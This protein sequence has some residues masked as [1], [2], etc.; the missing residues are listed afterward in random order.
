[1]GRSSHHRIL[2]FGTLALATA[3]AGYVLPGGA[4]LRHLVTNRAALH[5]TT[6][7]AEGTVSFFGGAIS[8]AGAALQ[9]PTDKPETQADATI[10]LRLPGRCR[11]DVTSPEGTRLSVVD[12]QGRLRN[13]GGVVQA[14]NVALGQVCHL[15]ALRGST[16]PETKAELERYLRQQLGVEPGG[17]WLDRQS[18]QVVFMLGRNN[19]KAAQFGV[20]KDS[21]LPA[22]VRFQDSA[23][24]PWEVRFVDYNS[25]SAGESFPRIIEVSRQG[26]KL[27]RLTVLKADSHANVSE[28]LFAL[29]P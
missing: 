15:L 24:I 10:S 13:E 6:L 18:D 29:A 21:F 11:L 14:L 1:M 27:L 20:F 2:L 12:S 3:A 28:K 23:Q 17:T 19:P 25:P 8:E 22:R 26:E 4:I 5:L 9:L 16:D 7:R